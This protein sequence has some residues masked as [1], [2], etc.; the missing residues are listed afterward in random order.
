MWLKEVLTNKKGDSMVYFPFYI[1]LMVYFEPIV[2]DY[3][4]NLT[5]QD[6]TKWD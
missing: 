4:L 1:M 5:Y 2:V 6:T 3:Q